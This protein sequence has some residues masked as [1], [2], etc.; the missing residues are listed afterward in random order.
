MYFD[1]VSNQW[2]RL[3]EARRGVDSPVIVPAISEADNNSTKVDMTCTGISIV[4]FDAFPT[5]PC[6]H[7]QTFIS[8]ASL[9]LASVNPIEIY[10]RRIGYICHPCK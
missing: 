4:Q 2:Q 10:D 8:L 6:M 9:H 5:Y 3:T 7:M 1:V